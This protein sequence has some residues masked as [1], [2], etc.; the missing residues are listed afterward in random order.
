[1]KLYKKFI[2]KIDVQKGHIE[3]ALKEKDSKIDKYD[4]LVKK[5][6]E[7]LKNPWI[8]CPKTTIVEEEERH[9]KVLENIP[10]NTVEINFESTNFK[11]Q[12]AYLL[13]SLRTNLFF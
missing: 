4:K 6:M 7:S 11:D 1:M 12:T 13:V 10:A 3:T 9:E 5:L 2:F 8:P